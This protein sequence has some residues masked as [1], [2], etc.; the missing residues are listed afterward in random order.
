MEGMLSRC[1]GD[2]KTEILGVVGPGCLNKD[3]KSFVC[4]HREA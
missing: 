1:I 2:V 3:P 4:G